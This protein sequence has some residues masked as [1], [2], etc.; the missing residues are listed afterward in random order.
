M[1]KILDCRSHTLKELSFKREILE[2]LIAVRFGLAMKKKQTF[3]IYIGK[4]KYSYTHSAVPTQE[5]IKYSYDTKKQKDIQVSKRYQEPPKEHWFLLKVRLPLVYL[6]SEINMGK[7]KSLSFFYLNGFRYK[8][9]IIRFRLGVARRK[10]SY[11]QILSFLA[12]VPQIEK[13]L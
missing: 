8:L 6:K 3:T 4:N 10:L 2:W 12:I 9:S 5:P 13:T 11:L 1:Y 7:S